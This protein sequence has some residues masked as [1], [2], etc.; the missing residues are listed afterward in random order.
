V[1]Q[2]LTWPQE[3]TGGYLWAPSEGKNGSKPYFHWTNLAQVQP[4]DVVVHYAKSRIQAISSVVSAATKTTRPSEPQFDSWNPAGWRVQTRYHFVADPI[5]LSEIPS[6]VRAPIPRGPFDRTGGVKQGYLFTLPD[7]STTRLQKIFHDRWPKGSPW[8]ADQSYDSSVIMLH[9][10]LK[11]N[12]A[13]NPHTIQAHKAIADR[14]GACWWGKFGTPIG[15]QRVDFFSGLIDAGQTPHVYLW[16]GSELWRCDILAIS[17]DP[18]RV[19]DGEI[20][21]YYRKEDCGTFLRLANWVE[22]DPKRIDELLVLDSSRA[23]GSVSKALRGQSSALFVLEL[24]P[25]GD[26]APVRGLAEAVADLSSKT[27]AAGLDYGA[28]HTEL[29]RTALVSL[30]TRRFLILTGL[31]GSGKTQLGRA[32]GQWFGQECWRVV[33][34]RP[35]WTG[36]DALLGYENGLTD[37]VGGRHA[38]NAPETLR[39]ML[40]AAANPMRPHLLL[41]DEMNLAHVER[42]F[43]DLLSGMESGDPVLANLVKSER[44]EWRFGDGPEYIPVPR[45]LF[46]VGTVNVDE[47]TYMFSPKVLDRA[48]TIEFRV[49]TEDLGHAPRHLGTVAAASSGLAAA[50]LTTSSNTAGQSDASDPWVV[51]S[52]HELHRLLGADGRE[53]GHRVF[54]EALRF[55]RLLKEAGEPDARAA[56]DLQVLQKVLPKFHGSVRQISAPLRRLAAW[57]YH[58]PG[59]APAPGFD[60]LAEL[61]TP[62]S[63]PLS[64]DKSLRM[65]R[66]LEVSHFV[67]F[68]E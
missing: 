32:I 67:S 2:G 57:C 29:I 53:F 55:A 10:L 34:V 49:V 11:W 14:L 30:A 41:L 52:L 4:G 28:R 1:N 43:A 18:G 23:A 39:F 9:L 31:S 5:A 40:R 13:R 51:E 48:N 37:S 68:A 46:I 62:G 56:L 24:T 6:A 45:N 60:P 7:D 17:N 16:G 63:L 36:P 64:F 27:K 8:Q 25:P 66:R 59:V 65:L 33:A 58:G 61:G 47:T 44:G 15:D 38:W 19:P 21:S 42:Y 3:S 26:A 20:P 12:P 50:V 35:D 54:Y 22:L